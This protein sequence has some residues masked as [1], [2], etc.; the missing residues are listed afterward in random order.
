M[1]PPVPASPEEASWEQPLPLPAPAIRRSAW[2]S[3]RAVI[4]AAVLIV[5]ASVGLVGMKVV[6][7]SQQVVTKNTAGPA[8]ALAGTIDPTKLSGEGDGRINILLLGI[9]GDGHSGGTLSDTIMVASVDPVHHTVAML[10]I[11]RDLYVRIPGHGASKINA[12]NSWGGP[13]LAKQVVGEVLDLPIHYYMQVDFQG[14]KQAVNAVGGVDI[15][16]ATL[17]SDAQYPCDNG[18][19]ICPF[20]LPA[21][22]YHMDG[23]QALKYA[24]CRNGTCGA[25]FGRA[26]RQQQL[27]IALREKAL[28]LSTLTN[29]LKISNLIDS[30]GNHVRTDMQLTELQKM[31]VAV[32]AIDSSKMTTKVLDGAPDGLLMSGSRQFPGAGAI[33]IPKA[34]AFNYAP[35]RELAHSLFIDSY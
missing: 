8:P 12:A 5:V 18:R 16:N 33:L 34:G 30:I 15:D 27:M 29:P 21:G 24:R 6:M 25:D 19:G 4:S 23:V 14:F 2:S 13:E 11:P 9:G 17:L 28:Q 22:D 1:Q 20:N 32:K 7:A 3:R 10:S 31:V 26:A 35:I